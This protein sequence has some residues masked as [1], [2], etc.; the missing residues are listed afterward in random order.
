MDIKRPKR[1]NEESEEDLMMMQEEFLKQKSEPSVKVTRKAREPDDQ[2]KQN[3]K[4]KSFK[5]YFIS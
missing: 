2:L 1:L 5:L 4:P 3:Q